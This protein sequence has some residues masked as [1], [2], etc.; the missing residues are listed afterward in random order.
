MI[1]L[2]NSFVNYQYQ[3]QLGQSIA[4]IS[5]FPSLESQNQP[6]GS[7]SFD[8]DSKTINIKKNNNHLLHTLQEIF[9]VCPL[10]RVRIIALGESSDYETFS[11]YKKIMTK[12]KTIL[13]YISPENVIVIQNY[14][15]LSII[16]PS[17]DFQKLFDDISGIPYFYA[18]GN[19]G[20]ILN[21]FVNPPE[22]LYNYIMFTSSI[23]CNVGNNLNN[24]SSGFCKPFQTPLT[25]CDQGG[26]GGGQYFSSTEFLLLEKSPNDNVQKQQ[27]VFFNS[28]SYASF[29][30]KKEKT[31]SK[32]QRS[33]PENASKVI[34]T[35]NQNN[36][37]DYE[38]E[39]AQITIYGYD[40][41]SYQLPF[42][43]NI[44]SFVNLT[45]RIPDITTRGGNYIFFLD[46][47]S[48]VLGNGT[49]FSCPMFATQYIMMSLFFQQKFIIQKGRNY[50]SQFYQ[51][52]IQGQQLF[53][54]FTGEYCIQQINPDQKTFSAVITDPSG[55]NC[56]NYPGY[57]INSVVGFNPFG[58]GVP[59]WKNWIIIS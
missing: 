40:L 53:I 18:P 43:K 1:P 58:L 11:F 14:G 35:T 19:Y 39:P 12:T 15:F 52:Q 42:N 46:S 24:S 21:N 31:V 44:P 26:A 3:T 45:F 2:I 28:C 7:I 29:F 33:H 13:Q 16:P 41:P 50:L 59:M 37:I 25:T 17:P 32:Q 27:S 23:F 34:T 8:F 48:T 47:S 51:L 22:Y 4:E 30:Y 36:F 10:A 6:P 38:T 54:Y 55:L 49:S 5:F 56:L 57:I 20:W 9:S